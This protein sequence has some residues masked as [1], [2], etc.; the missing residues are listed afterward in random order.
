[1]LQQ[2]SHIL[3]RLTIFMDFL[4]GQERR[5][6]QALYVAKAQEILCVAP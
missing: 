4:K 1:M 6:E 2:H 3:S 5:V